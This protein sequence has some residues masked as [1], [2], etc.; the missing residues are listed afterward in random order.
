MDPG[1]GDC[2]ITFADLP[3][4]L[5]LSDETGGII[6]NSL[7]LFPAQCGLSFHSEFVISVFCSRCCHCDVRT[8]LA[9]AKCTVVVLW[10]PTRRLLCSHRADILCSA[11]AT[12]ASLGPMMQV[13]QTLRLLMSVPEPAG[14]FGVW[15]YPNVT[16]Y[17]PNAARYLTSAPSPGVMYT[18]TQYSPPSYFEGPLMAVSSSFAFLLGNCEILI[19]QSKTANQHLCVT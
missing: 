10:P 11:C 3:P 2:L 16:G 9:S 5:T 8:D 6:S 12:R 17:I 4:A 13:S 19:V 18:T 1:S 14:M 15:G 7:G